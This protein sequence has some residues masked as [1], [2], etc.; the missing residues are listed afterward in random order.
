M[1]PRFQ[2]NSTGEFGN[3]TF[4]FEESN[5]SSKKLDVL[6]I[7]LGGYVER[8]STAGDWVEVNLYRSGLQPAPTA[9]GWIHKT[10][11]GA[12]FHQP[13][14]EPVPAISYV[15]ACAQTEERL[16]AVDS[17]VIP[18]VDLIALGLIEHE[19]EDSNVSL[20][21]ETYISFQME[22]DEP[23]AVGAFGITNGQWQL[24]LDMAGVA[25]NYD[26]DDRIHSR[27]QVDA[28]AYFL[29]EF[30]RRMAELKEQK[31]EEYL[32]RKVDL[33]CAWL[34]G[35]DLEQGAKAALALAGRDED[36]TLLSQKMT[37]FL[38]V[39]FG[40]ETDSQETA[41][42]FKRRG[43]FAETGGNAATVG[44]FLKRVKAV[45]GKALK[46]SV[47]MLQHYIPTF[48]DNGSLV[49]APWM[50]PARAQLEKWSQGW[51][52][53]SD[54]GQ[55][56]AL[57]FFAAT[58]H[59]PGQ[60][61]NPTTGEITDWCGAFAAWCMRESGVPVPEGA[62]RAANW[63]KWGD[64]DLPT[65]HKSEVPEG[66]VV[67]LSPTAGTET[68]GHV[69]F[70]DGWHE[71]APKFWGLGGN[72]GDRVTRQ[73]WKSENIIAIRALSDK[74]VSTNDDLNILARTL[75]GEIRGGDL[76][77]RRHVAIVILNRFLTGYRSGGSIAG[78]CR[79]PMQFSCWNPGT[80][81][82][83][84][85]DALSNDD[86]MLGELREIGQAVI[87]E[88]LGGNVEEL[89]LTVRHYHKTGTGADWA[90]SSKVVLKD[91]AHTFYRDIA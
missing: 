38:K 70:F 40:W 65:I 90:V 64:V 57:D 86:P 13:A 16:K 81:A 91:G 31:P 44:T 27:N 46:S 26:L 34:F 77:Q 74:T 76:E 19:L 89:G 29:R 8:I 11:L 39:T 18:A 14:E 67:M 60:V 4:V 61:T 50:T 78:T 3:S 15:F 58:N 56:E 71:T 32:P 41:A 87:A 82:R 2:V 28:A 17:L 53:H 79:A 23:S 54:P 47:V 52:E 55:A 45:Q 68:I 85:I 88:R 22:F 33:L 10:Y 73:A 72:Q 75:W 51:I 36:Q 84:Q 24:F 5:S 37:T 42:F 83:L 48:L 6:F 12:P 43:R 63:K 66:A 80:Q 7:N 20:N 9:K 59:G 69:C 30:W 62:A 35:P 21:D 1:L 49:A 25:L